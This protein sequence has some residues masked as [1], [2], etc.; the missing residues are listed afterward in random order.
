MAA[1][2]RLL[3]N[4]RAVEAHFEAASAGR[5]HLNFGIGVGFSDGGRQTDGAR[6]IISDGAV[7]NRQSHCGICWEIV[8]VNIGRVCGM[9]LVVPFVLA[10]S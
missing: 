5:N 4:G 3:E 7:L 2:P 8:F 10:L 9:A 1:E 6:F